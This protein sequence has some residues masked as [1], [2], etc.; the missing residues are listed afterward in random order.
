MTRDRQKGN[1]A[2]AESESREKAGPP[3]CE[4]VP[5]REA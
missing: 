1:A 4:P 2:R 5:E 3:S